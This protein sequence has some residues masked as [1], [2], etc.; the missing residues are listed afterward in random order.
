MALL[1]C[2]MVIEMWKHNLKNNFLHKKTAD[3][4]NMIAIIEQLLLFLLPKAASLQKNNNNKSEPVTL[5][6]KTTSP[7]DGT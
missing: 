1:Q 5:T 7:P 6:K 4:R 3:N 2:M